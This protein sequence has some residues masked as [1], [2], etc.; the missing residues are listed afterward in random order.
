MTIS[1]YVPAAWAT[2]NGRA[3]GFWGSVFDPTSAVNASDYPI[4]EFEGPTTSDPP[5][6]PGYRPNGVPGVGAAGF[7][8]WNNVTAQFEFIGLP[9]G[10][11]YN[12][13]VQLTYTLKPGIG[14]LY[15]VGNPSAGGVSIL[16]PLSDPLNSYVGNTILQGY[17]YG[18]DYN[19]FWGGSAAAAPAIDAYQLRYFTNV[20]SPTSGTRDSLINLSNTGAGATANGLLGFGAGNICANIY[21]F[22]PN[23]E[24]LACCGCTITPNALQS[25][26]VRAL[27]SS[28]YTP[29][30]ASSGVI[31]IL[32]SA[33]TCTTG[34]SIASLTSGLRAWGTTLHQTGSFTFGTETE[35]SQAPLSNGELNRLT[36]LCS[37]IGSNGS[38]YGVCPGCTTEGGR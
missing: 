4:I 31:K 32:A 14:F 20:D 18:A 27:Q 15:T 28:N 13:F 10:F 12:S 11:T 7:Y 25:V 23:E 16:S 9:A 2:L 36:N 6:G 22:D 34:G 19:I 30:F 17:N 37:V 3:A 1:L 24:E 8:G 35:F 33:G 29:E 21:V 38:G 5:N 26:S